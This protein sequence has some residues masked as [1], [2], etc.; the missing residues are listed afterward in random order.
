M[1]IK[2]VFSDIDG[3]FLDSGHRV[4]PKTA[5]AVKEL[6]AKDVPFVLVSAR[7]P[8]AIYPITKKIGIEIPIISYS[9]ALVLTKEGQELFSKKMTVADTKNVIEA[10]N[11]NFAGVTVNYYAGRKWFVR[12]TADK[13]VQQEM[14]ITSATAENA[15]FAAL[16]EK[17]TLPNKILV[18][19]EPGVCEKMEKE[20]GAMFAGLNVVRS[21][22]V[23]LEIMDKSVSKAKGIEVM[24]SHYGFA[25]ENALAFGD[26]YNDIEMLRYVGT[27]VA[28]KNAPDAIKK[29]ADEVTA[30]NDEEGIYEFLAKNSLV[31]KM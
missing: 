11:K 27:S 4:M 17:G 19:A 14:A 23:L 16:A 22:P 3:T 31:E 30:S 6:L 20:L 7:M 28:M 5:T 18:M 2:I 15:D 26:N 24:L 12:D 13:A 29:E 1:G 9:G 8:E 21:A 25:A 10:I